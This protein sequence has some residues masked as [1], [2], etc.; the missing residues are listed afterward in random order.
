MA[1]TVL[2]FKHWSSC[3]YWD[4]CSFFVLF[5]FRWGR[6]A[7]SYHSMADEWCRSTTVIWTCETT[8]PKRSVPNSTTMPW[9][10]PLRYLVILE[11][12]FDSLDEVLI[13]CMSPICYPVIRAE[14]EKCCPIIAQPLA[15]I[16]HKFA[17]FLIYIRIDLVVLQH[18]FSS[19]IWCCC[20][21]KKNA[22]DK[23]KQ[24]R[25]ILFKAVA[26]GERGKKSVWV[27]LCWKKTKRVFKSWSQRDR[28]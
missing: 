2:I 25:K 12:L 8:L 11:S 16:K 28:R 22:P 17:N 23:F 6:L 10:Q 26:I 5:C 20:Q 1:G 13:S 27:Q 4:T 9:D 3:D 18:I 19:I 24:A 15:D 21:S 14:G 7:L